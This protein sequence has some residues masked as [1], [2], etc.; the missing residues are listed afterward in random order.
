MA[1]VTNVLITL[2]DVLNRTKM[3]KIVTMS[4]LSEIM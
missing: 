3:L 4:Y 1:G 2:L